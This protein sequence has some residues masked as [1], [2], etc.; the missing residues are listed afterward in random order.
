MPGM[1]ASPV[2]K[3]S[4][5]RPNPATRPTSLWLFEGEE[6]RAGRSAICSGTLSCH[7][8]VLLLRPEEHQTDTPLLLHL[9]AFCVIHA[10]YVLPI[11]A[12]CGL[13]KGTWE[14]LHPHMKACGH[15]S[16]GLGKGLPGVLDC[17]LLIGSRRWK[18]LPVQLDAVCV[19]GEE[20]S[21]SGG[22]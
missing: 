4:V 8:L 21:T 11:S 1:R 3:G 14:K 17:W 15:L 16:C 10:L 22:H 5:A 6:K 7:T 19:V 9:K 13:N 2:C 12:Q 20:S 18:R